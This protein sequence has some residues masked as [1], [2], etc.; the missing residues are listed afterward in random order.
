MEENSTIKNVQ[1]ALLKWFENEGRE[2]PWRL[3]EN[4]YHI[5]LA[6]KLLQQ[7]LARD[8][9]VLAYNELINRY[10]NIRDLAKARISD[11]RGIIKPLGLHY[12]AKELIKMAREIVKQHQGTIPSNLSDLL[13]LTGV[14]DYSARAILSF[15]YN[16]DAPIVDTNV[17]RFLFRLLGLDGSIPQN[18]AR[19]KSL[20]NYAREF[21]PKGMSRNYNFAVLDLCSAICKSKKPQCLACPIQQFCDYGKRNLTA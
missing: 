16:K 4:P 21:I 17:A 6:E 12:R 19:S 7:T 10:P 20:R 14:G 9:V 2:F 11:I 13:A 1:L 15:A 18:P 3:T 5:L 8:Q